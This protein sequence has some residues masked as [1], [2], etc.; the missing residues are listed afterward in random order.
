M[1]DFEN[2]VFDWDS[3]IESDGKEYVTVQPGDYSFT[4]TNVER[5]NYPGN[6]SSGGKIPAC[7]MALVTGTID[8]PKGEATFRERLYLCKSF[9][10]KLSG[11]FR[12]L[13]MKKHGE[14]LRM[15]FQAAVGKKGLAKFGNHEHNGSTYNQIEQ[16]YDYDPDKLKGFTEVKDDDVPW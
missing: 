12:C 7:N 3:E 16:Y 6:L 5:Q 14:K 2:E 15:N 11:F 1:A 13:G 9:E 10:W 8:V 4:V